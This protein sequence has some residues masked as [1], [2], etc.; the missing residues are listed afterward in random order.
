MSGDITLSVPQIIVMYEDMLDKGRIALDGKAY[1]R[2]IDLKKSVIDEKL[3]TF[4]AKH[5]DIEL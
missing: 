3:K 5:K 4:L 1:Q 2:L